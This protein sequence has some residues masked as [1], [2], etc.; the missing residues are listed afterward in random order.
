M[1]LQY[2]QW[3]RARVLHNGGSIPR[4]NIRSRRSL[5]ILYLSAAAVLLA[6]MLD[7]TKLFRLI[8]LKAADLH[9]LAVNPH[10]PDN[11]TLIVVDQRTMDTF[12]EPR[13]FW[14]GYYAEAIE[15]A[16]AAGAKVLGLDLAFPIPVEKYAPGLDQRLASAVIEASTVM[17]VIC[18]YAGTTMQKQAD[19][20]VP[21]NMAAA[22]LGQMAYVNLTAD[23]DDFIPEDEG[24]SWT[25][26]NEVWEAL[27]KMAEILDAE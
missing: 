20:P 6:W 24:L 22:A 1:A 11:I 3:P 10:V 7:Q 9:Y 13:M 5:T 26:W 8:A 23:E 14:H 18:G 25:S 2:Q 16:A 15:A 17:P 4:M 27:V 19:W 21:M 12:S